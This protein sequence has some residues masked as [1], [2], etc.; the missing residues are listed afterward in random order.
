VRRQRAVDV[1]GE[2]QIAG[3]RERAAAVGIFEPQLGLD[4][5]GGRID[6][7]QAP[8]ET[9]GLLEA[10]AGKALARLDRAA[11]IDE[12]LLLDRLQIVATLE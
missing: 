11:L 7:L 9:L 12:V 2:D 6:R 1:A 4:L 3:G 10:A 5:A 8:V